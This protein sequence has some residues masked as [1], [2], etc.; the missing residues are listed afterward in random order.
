M[1]IILF[2]LLLKSKNLGVNMTVI[3]KFA[4]DKLYKGISCISDLNVILL[5][6][7]SSNDRVGPSHL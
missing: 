1:D 3:W 6:N 2:F 5:S 4:Y 7:I